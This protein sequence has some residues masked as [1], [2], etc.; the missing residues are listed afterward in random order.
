MNIA[1]ERVIEL[2]AKL[3]LTTIADVL[4]HLAQKAIADDISL[5][6]FLESVLKAEQL[7]RQS[8]QRI[9]LTRLAGFPAIKTLDSFDFSAASGV[10]RAQILELASLAFIER[11]ENIVLLGPSGTGKTHIAVALGYAATQVGIKV[12]FITA[13]DLL[14]ILTTAHRQ[15]QLADAL[16]R[17]VNP[18][19]LLIIDEI[20][21]LPMSRE[22]ANL[23]FQVIA[24]RYEHGSLIVTSN[25]PFG[26]WDQTFADDATLTAAM[27]DRL[28][29]HAHVV[30]IQGESFRLREKRRAGVMTKKSTTEKESLAV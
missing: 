17:F 23:F 5:T 19:R 8:R 13:A 29:H 24:K 1:H 9:T 3:K 4:P 30:P 15:N 28:L 25:L 27:L 11:S 10:P 20:G 6:E 21:Y 16:K 26:Q 2:C 18:Y 22:Q 7:A 14:M 12:R